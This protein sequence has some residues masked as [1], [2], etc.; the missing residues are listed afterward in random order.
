MMR[1]TTRPGP[2]SRN[3]ICDTPLMYSRG[4]LGLLD[5]TDEE[6]AMFK[7]VPASAWCALIG[8]MAASLGSL[9]SHAGCIKGM[10]AGGAALLLLADLNEHAH[11][12]AV[13]LRSQ[14]KR[15]YDLGSGTKPPDHHRV[16]PLRPVAPAT[17]AAGH[18]G[19][20][21]PTVAQHRE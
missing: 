19:R 12:A 1:S 15:L 11:P 18:G 20:A 10:D 5:L 2:R 3:I 13:R 14:W 4:A 9:S 16:R 8:D 6:K 17:C 7:P 21:A